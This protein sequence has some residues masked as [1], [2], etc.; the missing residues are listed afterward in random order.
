MG[1]EKNAR[2]GTRAGQL[3]R[4]SPDPRETVKIKPKSRIQCTDHRLPPVI[5]SGAPVGSL[6]RVLHSLR[7]PSLPRRL[8][9]VPR[10]ENLNSPGRGCMVGHPSPPP[11]PFPQKK[12]ATPDANTVDLRL[13]PPAG[14]D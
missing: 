4:E 13:S 12:N 10:R 3:V 11:G 14:F 7:S 9:D 6:A 8:P 2:H 5:D 1:T